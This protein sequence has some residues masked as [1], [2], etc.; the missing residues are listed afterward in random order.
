MEVY[1]GSKKTN[2]SSKE[3]KRTKRRAWPI[4]A[5]I[6]LSLAVIAVA[7]FLFLYKDVHFQYRIE[8]GDSMPSADVF[9][10]THY[11]SVKYITDIS[12]VSE[13]ETAN[14]W[15]RVYAN[16]NERLVS[17]VVEDTTPPTAQPIELSIAINQEITP[18]Q[19]VTDIEDAGLVKIQWHQAPEFG[20]AGDY[21]VVVKLQDLSGNTALVSSMLYIRATID[22]LT[23][24]AG[25]DQPT[26]SDFLADEALVGTFVTDVDALT[27]SIPGEY[28]VSIDVGGTVYT[29]MLIIEDTVAPEVATQLVYITPG[30]QAQPEDFVSESTDATALS[31]DFLTAPDFGKIGFQDVVVMATDL[32]GNTTQETATLLISNAAP[33]SLEIRE[34]LL[35]ADDFSGL[36]AYSDVTLANEMVP[37]TLGDFDIELLLDGEVNP[38][39]VTV[40]DTTP[41]TAE[42]VAV[43]WYVAHALSADRF[44][45]DA[46]DYTEISYAFSNEPD[47]SLPGA[48]D[49][50]IVLTDTSGNS[51]EFSTTL[52]LGYD[53][54][55]PK[56]YGVKDRY[57]YIGQPVAYFAEVFAEDN[58]DEEVKIEVNNS[59][60]NIH[61]A[62]EY[63]VTYTATDS[64][65]NTTQLSC[66][67]TF[68]E[69]TVSQEE[70]DTVV[71]SVFS[72]ILTDDMSLAQK[73]YAV[74]KYV[75]RHVKYSGGSNKSDW[76]YEA[77]RGI[78]TGR[79]D[80]FTFF[81]TA[82]YLLEEIGAQTISVERSGGNKTTRHYWLLVDVGTGW[83]HVD[84]T[85]VGPVGYDCFMRTDKELLSKSRNYW[86][87]DRSLYPPTPETPF[88]L[89]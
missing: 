37:D 33:I 15:L 60:V 28:Q 5:G 43:D 54:E 71:Q 25:S 81:A 50:S 46:F 31:F 62:G 8:L 39:R 70:L 72:S 48:Q 23:M 56:L 87:F 47:W 21:P 36:S 24:E 38:T 78:T 76:K 27:L 26:L 58:C 77:Y 3:H 10:K 18:D 7:V 29:S 79:G 67:F 34:A 74:F 9:A 80:C 52:T 1:H 84:A 16:G 82:K 53:T 61:Q 66:T 4:V 51:A 14:H 22:T 12:K 75:T 88:I 73:A 86:S 49:V 83:Y 44:V 41:P 6:L 63:T 65:G 19:M 13:S 40:I 30:S 42:P 59:E 64:S 32:G 55:P 69:E 20:I 2:Q 85:N 57:C 68:V 35:T 45:Q 11:V 17:L 89:E